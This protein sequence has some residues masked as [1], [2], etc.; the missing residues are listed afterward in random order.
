M[1]MRLN[2]A[3]SPAFPDLRMDPQDVLVSGDKVVARTRGTGT[4]EGDFM[5]MPATGRRSMSS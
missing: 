1:Q 3:M 2:S 5:G 4:H